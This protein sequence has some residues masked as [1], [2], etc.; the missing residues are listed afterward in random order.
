[1]VA[2]V[3]ERRRAR[4]RQRRPAVA[5]G[6]HRREYRIPAVVATGSATSVLPDGQMVTVDGTTGRVHVL[7]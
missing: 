4:H 2:V 5:P 3:P 6:D 1:V 7:G